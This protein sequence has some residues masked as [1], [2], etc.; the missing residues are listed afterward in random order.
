MSHLQPIHDLALG[1]WRNLLPEFGI[2]ESYLTGKHGPCPICKDGTDRWRY[3]DKAGRGTW[4]CSHC[5]AGSGVDLV[6]R[7]LGCDFQTAH[8]AIL[9]KIPSAAQEPIA[10]A[11]QMSSDRF[12]AQFN[13]G[14]RL[15]GQDAA[16]RYLMRRGIRFPSWPAMLRFLPRAAYF[17]D[18]TK[19]RS[20]HPAMAA[21]YVCP[22]TSKQTVHFT[23]LTEDGHKASVPKPKKLAP[24]KVP[25]GGA[26]RLGFSASR[27]GIAEGIE[28]AMAA[29]MLFG[30]PVWSALSSGRLVKWRPPPGASEVVVFGDND[31]SFAGQN[32]AY[33]L[34]YRLTT[35]G[36]RVE[37]EIPPRIETDWNDVL[38]DEATI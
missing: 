34:A 36:Y 8:K 14:M 1:R 3:D 35:E 26:V 15:D 13:G 38:L 22:E 28:T 7:V 27:M 21:L 6:M 11:R 25:E 37:V 16:S 24:C 4:F 29:S 19:Q 10:K 5:G 23:F 12:V 17:D 18:A 30:I 2:H 31:R 9:E 33:G 20:F 32:A